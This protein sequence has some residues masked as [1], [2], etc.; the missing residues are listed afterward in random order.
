MKKKIAILGSTG[1]IGKT[2][3]E[4]IK[5]DKK[6][7]EVVLLTAQKNEVSLL[8]QAKLLNVKNLIITNSQ[9]FKNAVK[10][11]SNK[12]INIYNDYKKFNKIFRGKVDYVMNSISGIEGLKPTLEIIKHTKKIAVANKES[13]ICGWN[14]I[15]KKLKFYKTEFIPIDSEHFSI[16]ELIKNTNK[17]NIEKVFI[18]ASGGPF[19]NY[20]H[21]SFKNIKVKNAINHPTWKMGKKISIDSA[22]LINKVYELIEAKKIFNLDYSKF[23]I[24]VQPTSFIHSIIR[25]YGGILKVL[26]HDTSMIIPIFNSLYD[27]KKFNIKFSPNINLKLFNNLNLQKVPIKKFPINKILTHLPKT[28]SLF[29]TVLVSSN[30][31]LV[32]L[33]LSKKISFNDIHIYLNKILSLKEFQK[34]KRK[35]PKNLTEILHLNEY[36][37]LK[38]KSLSVV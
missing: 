6:S 28:D 18:T 1:S 16:N 17:K 25:F 5:K 23:D 20:K 13:I 22:T 26:V 9:S 7:F 11:R 24:L 8:K 12:K 21:S 33:F 35:K 15:N 19:L 34:Y 37:R 4:I 2:L 36:V 14:L 31:T 10:K 3:I 38:T 30:D 32:N 27:T 29:E